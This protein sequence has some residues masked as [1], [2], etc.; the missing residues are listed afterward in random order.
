M[1]LAGAEDKL[2]Q[3]DAEQTRRGTVIDL[4]LPAF[5]QMA[6]HTVS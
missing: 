1:S 5:T 6:I 2:A 4:G 3:L